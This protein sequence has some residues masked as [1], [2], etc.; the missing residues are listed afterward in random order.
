M[1]LKT[2]LQEKGFIERDAEEY[3]KNDHDRKSKPASEIEPTY[4]PIN[5]TGATLAQS[6]KNS[7]ANNTVPTSEPIDKAFI[8]FFEDELVRVNLPGPDYFEFR[9]Q[10]L[11]MHEKIGK[12]G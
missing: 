2:F 9:K 1:S 10:M 12:K 6:S 8:K 5:D 11:A 3:N 7:S 4:F